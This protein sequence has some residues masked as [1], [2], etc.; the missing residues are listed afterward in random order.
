MENDDRLSGSDQPTRRQFLQTAGSTV[1]AGVMAAYAPAQASIIASEGT[2]AGADGPAVEGM[3]PVTLRI[4]GKDHQ[5]RLDPNNAAGLLTR[6]GSAHRH[7]KGLRSWA[8]RRL[9]GSCERQ[10]RAFM[11]QLRCHARWRRDHNHRG[12]GYARGNASH[13]SGVFHPRCL[14]MWLL[15]LGTDHVRGRVAEGAMRSR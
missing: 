3:V 2:P 5:L 8:M 7:K 4:N 1:A 12:P 9:Y 10:P 6:N 15:H 11:P 13:A 14:P